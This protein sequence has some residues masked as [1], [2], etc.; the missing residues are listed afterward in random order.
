MSHYQIVLNQKKIK[1]KRKSKI[2]PGNPTVRREDN[3]NL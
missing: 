3:A 1:M 2:L